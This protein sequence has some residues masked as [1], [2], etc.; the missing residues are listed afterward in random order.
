MKT[1][2]FAL[3][4]FLLTL[5]SNAYDDVEYELQK[6]SRSA[7]IIGD[8][9]SSEIGFYEFTDREG[10]VSLRLNTESSLLDIPF[11]E[12]CY[13][14]PKAEVQSI[15]EA[16]AGNTNGYYPQG[17]H[18][19]INKLTFK[20]TQSIQFDVAYDSDYDQGEV[21]DTFNLKKCN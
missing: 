19:Y 21:R 1:T 17:G 5:N 6:C 16:L 12:Y 9:D 14:G 20:N 18:F 4:I 10:N 11:N 15:I 13:R 7:C 8:P 2:A 3:L